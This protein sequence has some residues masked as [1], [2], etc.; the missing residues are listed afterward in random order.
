MISCSVK[1]FNLQV[2]IQVVVLVVS[3]KI[4]LDQVPK[5]KGEINPIIQL[6]KSLSK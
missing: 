3:I 6:G 1:L 4:V 5:G 2:I